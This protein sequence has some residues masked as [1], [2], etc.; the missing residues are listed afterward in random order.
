MFQILINAS[1]AYVRLFL[2]IYFNVTLP[3]L[4]FIGDQCCRRASQL[5]LL[6]GKPLDV[7]QTTGWL[8]GSRAAY[9]IYSMRRSPA[10][11]LGIIMILASV[12]WIAADLMVSG[13]VVPVQVVDRCP[14]NTTGYMVLSKNHTAI[15]PFVPSN[16]G[17]LWDIVTRATSTSQSNGGLTGIFHKANGD[18]NFRAD[19]EDIIGRWNCEMAGD[20]A[21]YESQQSP[22]AIMD[23]LLLRNLLYGNRT[24]CSTNYIGLNWYT[25]LLVLSSSVGD[26]SQ[27]LENLTTDEIINSPLDFPWD[28]R[29]AVD[30]APNAS[31]TKIMRPYYCSLNASS[32]EILLGKLQA[33]DT[34]QFF[35]ANFRANIY[36][37]FTDNI[38]MTVD[39]GIAVAS[40]LDTIMMMAGAYQAGNN[41]PP[42]EIEDPYQGC[43]AT[44]TKIPAA[45]IVMW[46]VTTLM[47]LGLCGYWIILAA[48]IKKIQRREPHHYK[49]VDQSTLN[50]LLDWMRHAVLTT[51]LEPGIENAGLKNWRLTLS[52]HKRYLSLARKG[53]EIEYQPIL[54][55]SSE[56]SVETQEIKLAAFPPAERQHRRNTVEDLSSSIE[57]IPSQWDPP[58]IRLGRVPLPAYQRIPRKQVASS[59]T[60]EIR[61]WDDPFED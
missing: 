12:L 39:P 33:A 28:V 35:C 53:E 4:G 19:P 9:V 6:R 24:S 57:A 40:M 38:P 1:S 54:A 42:P 51:G 26:W 50:G 13:F 34:L 60:A 2:R 59:A 5:L 43:L 37:Y 46:I 49:L 55:R 23:D 29:A 18:L 32:L 58:T 16:V 44:R 25:Q 56:I 47:L 27:L 17:G 21:Q 30:M 3:L 22:D 10:G 31:D 36:K 41:N 7:T 8:R 45:V 15:G 11:L 61:T 20:D 14:F 52:D 48:R